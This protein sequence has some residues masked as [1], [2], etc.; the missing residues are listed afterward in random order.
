M[1]IVLLMGAPFDFGVSFK[2]GMEVKSK[3]QKAA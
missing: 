3:D 2:D 1:M